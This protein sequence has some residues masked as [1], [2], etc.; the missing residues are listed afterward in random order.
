[1]SLHIEGHD[2]LLHVAVVG[3]CGG[4]C[5]VCIVLGVVDVVVALAVVVV[6]LYYYRRVNNIPQ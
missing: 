6:L 1:M 2:V 3:L 4:V 5:G